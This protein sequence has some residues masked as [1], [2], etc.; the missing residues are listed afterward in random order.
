MYKHHFLL[1][2]LLWPFLASAQQSHSI[3]HFVV[4][5]NLIKNGKLAIIATDA[6]EVPTDLISGTYQFT[7]NGFSQE[8][9]FRDGIA[10]TPQAIETSAFVFI[11]HRNE[12]GSHGRLYYIFKSGDGLNP[13]PINW[14]YLIL[15]PVAIL[16]IAYVFKRLM[17][18]AIVILIGL[19]VFNYSQGLNLD[20]L[21]D[22]LMHGIKEFGLGS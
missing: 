19:F 8:L 11:K 16:L 15:I 6:N 9:N 13:V 10:I 18:L 5:E 14:Y 1:I 12:S 20:T 17:V 22:T 21:F 2:I 7:V 3:N 4:R